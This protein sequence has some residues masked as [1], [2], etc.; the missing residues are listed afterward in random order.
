M[1]SKKRKRESDAIKQDTELQ[2]SELRALSAEELAHQAQ[3]G[4]EASFTAL[5]ERYRVRLFH[6]LHH[7]TG[8]VQDAEDLVQDTFVKAYKNIHRYSNSWKFSTWLFTIA[9]RLASS[10]YRS[11]R[12]SQSVSE[13]ESGSLEPEE[14]ATQEEARQSLWAMA[15]GLSK[16]QYQALRLRYAEDMSIKEI[17]QV[18][19]KSQVNVKVI[20]YRARINMAERLRNTAVEDEAA[21]QMSSKETVSFMKVEGA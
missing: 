12:R 9:R 10:H 7:K 17:A 11:L 6:F 3:Q 19:R 20:L 4:C 15:R 18:L 8:S 21:D 14:M 13:V 1:E 16:N 2:Q 5:A